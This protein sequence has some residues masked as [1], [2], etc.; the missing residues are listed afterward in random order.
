MDSLCWYEIQNLIGILKNPDIALIYE[1]ELRH[2]DLA[3][4]LD[5][6]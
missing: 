2:M 5:I 4:H 6:G 1:K 3:F